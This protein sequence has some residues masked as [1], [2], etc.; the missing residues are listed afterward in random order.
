MNQLVRFLLPSGNQDK[1]YAWLLLSLRVLFGGLLLSHGLQ[2]WG[3]F[4]TLSAVFPDPMGMGSEWSLSLAIFGEVIC[5]ILFI[6]GFA[7]RLVLLPMI[8]TMGVAFFVVH[9]ADPFAVKELAFVYL[10]VFVVMYVAG[11]GRYSVDGWIG[12]KMGRNE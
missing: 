1:S 4:D 8:F 7:Y 9:G 2:K 3:A 12:R 11:A 6:V 10:A 5:S